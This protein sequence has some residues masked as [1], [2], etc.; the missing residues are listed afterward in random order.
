MV[1][2]QAGGSSRHSAHLPATEEGATFP[3]AEGSIKSSLKGPAQPRDEEM[4]HLSPLSPQSTL[5]GAE[6][7]L[8]R[9]RRRSPGSLRLTARGRLSWDNPDLTLALSWHLPHQTRV[10]THD[11]PTRTHWTGV[12]GGPYGGE[13]PLGALPAHRQGLPPLQPYLQFEAVALPS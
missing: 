8:F 9:E 11:L 7:N 12:L 6:W 10:H 2:G 4:G 1:R 13:T 5:W 3:K